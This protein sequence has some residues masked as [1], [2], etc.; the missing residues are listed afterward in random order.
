MK[1]LQH[2]YPFAIFTYYIFL[3]DQNILNPR[4][5]G[6]DY[7]ISHPFLYSPFL[8]FTL[9]LFS[10]FLQTFPFVSLLLSF[11]ILSKHINPL[12]MNQNSRQ[13]IKKQNT[14]N[15]QTKQTIDFN[16]YFARSPLNHF[17]FIQAYFTILPGKNAITYVFLEK[18]LKKRM[19]Q[20]EREKKRCCYQ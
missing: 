19:R 6:P 18:Y 7:E 3:I 1:M 9:A 4:F 5:D 14:H 16:R 13:T 12:V 2:I 8:C 11:Y 17:S 10:I 15:S 20:I